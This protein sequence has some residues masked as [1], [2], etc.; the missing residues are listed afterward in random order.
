MHIQI[1]LINSL[2]LILIENSYRSIIQGHP[3]D[4]FLNIKHYLDAGMTDNL[5]EVHLLLRFRKYDEALEYHRQSLVLVPQNAATLSSIGYVYILTGRSAEAVDYF[6]KA[7]GLRR[8]D[9]FSTTMLG[10][11]VEQLMNEM[12]P[13]DGGLYYSTV[14]NRVPLVLEISAK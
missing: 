6:H 5:F 9:T 4:L 1:P 2:F 11:A 8:D 12:T 10:N 13:C 7:L 3:S 14:F